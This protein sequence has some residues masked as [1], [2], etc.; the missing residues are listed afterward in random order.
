MLGMIAKI[1]RK[2]KVH[3]VDGEYGAVTTID[4]QSAYLEKIYIT[5]EG[6]GVST[7]VTSIELFGMDKG[8]G[9]IFLKRLTLNGYIGKFHKN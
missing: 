3:K 6:K 1:N 2:I 4:G 9:K 5:S 8:L 7:K